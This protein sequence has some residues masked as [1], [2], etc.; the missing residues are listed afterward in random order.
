M[1]VR[2]G[3]TNFNTFVSYLRVFQ[4]SIIPPVFGQ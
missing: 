3:W 2:L 4:M 1:I